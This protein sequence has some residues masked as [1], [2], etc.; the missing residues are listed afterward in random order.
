MCHSFLITE[1]SE[2]AMQR[3]AFIKVV[4]QFVTWY[5]FSYTCISIALCSQA[6]RQS[7]TKEEGADF[8]LSDQWIIKPKKLWIKR[9]YLPFP[10]SLATPLYTASFMTLLHLLSPQLYLLLAN[11]AHSC[12]YPR[13]QLGSVSP[14]PRNYAYTR[15]LTPVPSFIITCFTCSRHTASLPC[16]SVDLRRRNKWRRGGVWT[17][18]CQA[19]PWGPFK[20]RLPTPPPFPRATQ[21]RCNLLLEVTGCSSATRRVSKAP[22]DRLIISQTKVYI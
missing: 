21:T 2:L 20:P 8:K 19:W 9:L 5:R 3:F 14:T 10:P 13:P 4:M 11:V 7:F 15:S 12:F 18:A 17:K 16:T 22:G 1:A 6:R